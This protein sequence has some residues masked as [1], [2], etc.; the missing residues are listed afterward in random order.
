MVWPAV[1]GALGS[2]AGGLLASS[3][4]KKANKQNVELNKENREWE[5]R[6]SNTSYTRAVEDLKNAGLNPMLAYSQGGASTPNHS[7][8]SVIPEDALARGV[9]SASDKAMQSML[10]QQQ[11]ANIKLTEAQTLKAIEE[12][13][14]AGVTAA[15]AAARQHWEIQQIR[16][17]IEGVISRY[18]LTDAQRRQVQEMLPFVIDQAKAQIEWTGQQTSASKTGQTLST[19]QIPE[20]EASAKLWEQVSEMGKAAQLTAGATKSLFE[21]A[22]D[23]IFRRQK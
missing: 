15:N 4:Q 11:Q 3:A 6:M 2:V 9:S 10:I 7:A 19:L 16:H 5:E 22:K 12:A 8:A 23:Y 20:A 18:Q 21:L 1:I 17:D 13:K 14:T